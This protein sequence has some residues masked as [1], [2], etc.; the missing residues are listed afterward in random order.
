[1]LPLPM[2]LEH[3]W[4]VSFFF[5]FFKSSLPTRHPFFLL[6]TPTILCLSYHNTQHLQH[7][8]TGVWQ[9]FF[10]SCLTSCSL[11]ADIGDCL[12][13]LLWSLEQS[14]HPKMFDKWMN[15]WMNERC[16]EARV[17]G[18]WFRLAPN[19]S[20]HPFLPSLFSSYTFTSSSFF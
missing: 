2:I 15:E 19:H 8:V 5:F 12:L 13:C 1:M 3:W 20:V 10:S 14:E 11:K 9:G 18:L 16:D 7:C 17:S 4:N 6:W